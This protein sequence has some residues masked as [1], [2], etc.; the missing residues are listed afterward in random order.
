MADDLRPKDDLTYERDEYDDLGFVQGKVSTEGAAAPWKQILGRDERAK[1]I[2]YADQ[3]L[4]L[5]KEA[6]AVFLQDELNHMGE[7]INE[8]R[9]A[10]KAVQMADRVLAQLAIPAGQKDA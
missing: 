3:R 5:A 9:I 2:P 10:F 4:M 8:R 6:M 1:G 7:K